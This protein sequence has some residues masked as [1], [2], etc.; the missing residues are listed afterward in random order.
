MISGIQTEGFKMFGITGLEFHTPRL[1]EQL[2]KSLKEDK[3]YSNVKPA[4]ENRVEIG[5]NVSGR[6]PVRNPDDPYDDHGWC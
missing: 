4:Q 5:T 1:M 3:S 6:V 2:E